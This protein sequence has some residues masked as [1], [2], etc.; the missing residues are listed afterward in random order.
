MKL[1]RIGTAMATPFSSSG[2]IDYEKTGQLI[3]HLIGSGSDSI[4]VCGTTGESPALSRTEKKELIQFTVKTANGRVPIIAGCGTNNTAQSIELVKD[5]ELCGAD[6]IMLVTPYYNKPDQKSMYAHFAA[7]AQAAG[8]PVLLYNVP[9][10]SAV[11]LLPET[12]IA[13]AA[14]DNIRAVKEASGSLGQMAAIIKGT[15]D[16]F[17]VYSGDDSLTLPLLSIGGSG[18]ISVA[19]HIAGSEMQQMIAAYEQGETKKAAQMHLALQPLFD[20]LFSAP[21]PLPLKYALAKKGLASAAVRLPLTALDMQD[22]Q[23]ID[24]VL[25]KWKADSAVFFK[26]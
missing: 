14:I 16:D 6:G 24:K 9:G 10:R 4:I 19:S 23:K 25:E 18:V 15:P 12:V 5:A 11:N 22:Q 20:V 26:K 13:L 8:L 1:G 3:E 17:Q 7:I 2:L 21:N